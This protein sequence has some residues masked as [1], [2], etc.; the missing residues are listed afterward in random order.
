MGR[1]RQR[2]EIVMVAIEERDEENND[3]SGYKIVMVVII[4]RS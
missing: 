4:Q 1:G 3:G 2:R